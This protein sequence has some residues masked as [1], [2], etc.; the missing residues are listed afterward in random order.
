VPLRV[1]A[2]VASLG[3]S[4]G[5]TGP[6]CA[7]APSIT[8]PGVGIVPLWSDPPRVW[9]ARPGHAPDPRPIR[10]RRCVLCD[11]QSEQASSFVIEHL[12]FPFVVCNYHTFWK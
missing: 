10:G 4:E 1:R 5:L 11:A 9:C 12:L 2:L 3:W 8:R 6:G 7:D